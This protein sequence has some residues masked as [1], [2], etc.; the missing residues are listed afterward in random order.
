[1]IYRFAYDFNKYLIKFFPLKL[2]KSNIAS[3]KEMIVQDS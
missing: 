1:M 3:S 2:S